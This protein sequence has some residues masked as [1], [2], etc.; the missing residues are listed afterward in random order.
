MRWQFGSDKEFMKRTTHFETRIQVSRMDGAFDDVSPDDRAT[1]WRYDDAVLSM[2]TLASA[3]G[4]PPSTPMVFEL[5]E[6]DFQS[7]QCLCGVRCIPAIQDGFTGTKYGCS[8]SISVCS[9]LWHMHC[10]RME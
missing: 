5:D 3:S 7:P 2:R 8:F 9:I 4:C 10:L 6:D 1:L